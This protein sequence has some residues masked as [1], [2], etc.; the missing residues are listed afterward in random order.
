VSIGAGVSRETIAAFADGAI[1]PTPMIGPMLGLN[2]IA[3]TFD[4][5]RRAGV[6]GRMLV[7]ASAAE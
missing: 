6:H 3:D 7:T 2:R 1:D 4:L 5:V